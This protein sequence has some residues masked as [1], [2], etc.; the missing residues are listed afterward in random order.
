[1]VS[2]AAMVSATAANFSDAAVS[3]IAGTYDSLAAGQRERDD[4]LARLVDVVL[5][6]DE[7][8]T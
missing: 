3:G 1:M 5:A 8:A 7:I 6:G 2:D 4:T